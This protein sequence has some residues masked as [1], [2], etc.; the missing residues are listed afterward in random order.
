[1]NVASD[2]RKRV[3]AQVDTRQLEAAVIARYGITK[4]SMC[5]SELCSKKPWSMVLGFCIR[6]L[7]EYAWSRFRVFRVL[8]IVAAIKA[9]EAAGDTRYRE[10]DQRYLLL[11][12][13]W[14][15]KRGG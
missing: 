14:I 13:K 11:A 5:R 12:R 15:T 4:T 7:G 9:R 8:H 6:Q 3:S 1:M 10:A 2:D